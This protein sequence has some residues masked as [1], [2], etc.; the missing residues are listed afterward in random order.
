[1]H[2]LVGHLTVGGASGV[3]RQWWPGGGIAY[4]YPQALRAPLTVGIRRYSSVSG[5]PEP[6]LVALLRV[7]P[8]VL[9]F[10]HTQC[11][12]YGCPA[13]REFGG[14]HTKLAYTGLPACVRRPGQA[15]SLNPGSVSI[16][17]ARGIIC[18]NSSP[19]TWSVAYSRWLENNCIYSSNPSNSVLL[20]MDEDDGVR[21]R[22][23]S[24]P[25]VPSD[26]W[27]ASVLPS[28][29]CPPVLCFFFPRFPCSSRPSRLSCLSARSRESRPLALDSLVCLVFARARV[30]VF[31]FPLFPLV[32]FSLVPLVSLASLLARP[33]LASWSLGSMTR[34]VIA[35]VRRTRFDVALLWV[36]L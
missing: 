5:V 8:L 10:A 20:C 17:I 16:P 2:Q 26:F 19:L 21:S 31:Y 24:V 36:S 11:S 32:S 35:L 27:F 7:R 33:S 12:G 15:R 13:C 23:V 1:M 18:M 14:R 4:P 34:L 30:A 22:P 29:P 25:L 28:F 6:V 3:P 9:P